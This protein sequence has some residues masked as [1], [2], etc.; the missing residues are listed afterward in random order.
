[1][2]RNLGLAKFRRR[3]TCVCPTTVLLPKLQSKQNHRLV[4]YSR[5]SYP[6]GAWVKRSF[7]KL[8]RL[9]IQPLR[10]ISYIYLALRV[11]DAVPHKLDKDHRGHASVETEHP[12]WN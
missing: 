12:S 8:H 1:M 3:L 4:W 7:Y 5:T 11:G 6:L 10:H 2:T 9:Y